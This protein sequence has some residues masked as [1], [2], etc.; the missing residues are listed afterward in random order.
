MVLIGAAV[1][2]LLTSLTLQLGIMMRLDRGVLL[3]I[4]ISDAA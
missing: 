3:V 4:V 1:G 2:S